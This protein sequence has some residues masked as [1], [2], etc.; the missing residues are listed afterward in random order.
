[1]S[2]FGNFDDVV[3]PLQ[4]ILLKGQPWLAEKDPWFEMSVML[5]LKYSPGPSHSALAEISPGAVR[6]VE[7]LARRYSPAL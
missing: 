6:A 1:M 3:A 2:L 7:R 4:A 5:A